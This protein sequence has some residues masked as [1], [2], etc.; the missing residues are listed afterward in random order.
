M[1]KVLSNLDVTHVIKYPRPNF[2]C[3]AGLK[4]ICCTRVNIRKGREPGNEASFLVHRHIIFLLT[5]LLLEK[6]M[7]IG[8]DNT[9]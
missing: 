1:K 5:P 6:L 8:P 9:L 7:I 4:V 3:L 2:K